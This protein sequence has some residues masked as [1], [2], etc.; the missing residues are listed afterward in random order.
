MSREPPPSCGSTSRVT[1]SGSDEYS[2]ETNDRSVDRARRLR[3]R[4]VVLAQW[5]NKPHVGARQ[6]LR[7]GVRVRE[8]DSAAAARLLSAVPFHEE[9][10]GRPRS[11]TIRLSRVDQTIHRHL[12]T[13]SRS[14]GNRRDAAEVVAAAL[15]GAEAATHE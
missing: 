14:T 12:G 5:S 1:R 7:T 8:N 9:A 2:S 15:G 4:G 6:K 10:Q 3:V 13:R 11:R